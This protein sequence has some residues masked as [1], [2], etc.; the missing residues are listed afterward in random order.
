MRRLLL[1]S[2]VLAAAALAAQRGQEPDFQETQGDFK[3]F[4][5]PSWEA[6]L[7]PDGPL[8]LT[9]SGSPF[10]AVS[11]SR[12]LELSA[13]RLR[14]RFD[15]AKEGKTTFRSGALEG[16]VQIE[17][18]KES[19]GG[20]DRLEA[21][22]ERIEIVDGEKEAELESPGSLQFRSEAKAAA[23]RTEVIDGRAGRGS[24]RLAPLTQAEPSG[25]RLR[26]ALLTGGAEVEFIRREG[27]GPD[28][29]FDRI[30]IA[31]SRISL[32]RILREGRIETSFELPERFDALQSVVFAPGGRALRRSLILKAASGSGMLSGA[33]SGGQARIESLLLAGPVE[34]D[35]EAD[36]LDA[37]KRPI[38]QKAAAA[39]DSARAKALSG[40]RLQID[41]EGSIRFRYDR[42][43]L[44]KDGPDASG[45]AAQADR[46]T[47]VLDENGDI[48]SLK[49]GK[50][51]VQTGGG[52]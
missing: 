44:G 7:Q 18:R 36:G 48:V 28:S 46:L 41:L 11:P 13:R 34:I 31:S 27:S 51:A 50:G 6:E 9:G 19:E 47:L 37:Q 1:A 52:S 21:A 4:G 8:L 15:V 43:P 5:M 45:Y 29:A 24:F 17:L 23:G 2:A 42:T 35:A 30:R 20:S 3:V 33:G 26:S 16:G 38:R 12:G 14:A 22:S 32:S 25:G 40:G 10:R 39:A 49:A